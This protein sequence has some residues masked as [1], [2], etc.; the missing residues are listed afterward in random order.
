MTGDVDCQMQLYY[1]KEKLPIVRYR[2]RHLLG[3]PFAKQVSDKVVTFWPYFLYFFIYNLLWSPFCIIPI[4][5][6]PLNASFDKDCLCCLLIL[7]E[8]HK[9]TTLLAIVDSPPG[10]SKQKEK[11]KL[12]TLI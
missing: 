4:K 11:N 5:G 6:A 9:L 8:E 10:I 2:N 7:R 12:S 1:D 3:M